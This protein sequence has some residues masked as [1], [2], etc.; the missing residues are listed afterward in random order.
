MAAW[1]WARA[2]PFVL[3]DDMWT[4][5]PYL[6]RLVD[7]INARPAAIRVAALKDKHAFKTE[8]DDEARRHLFPQNLAPAA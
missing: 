1:G 2:L 7:E 6:K 8:L 5:L 4:P 3:G